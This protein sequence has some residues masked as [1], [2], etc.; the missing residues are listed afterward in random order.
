[1][2]KLFEIMWTP[3]LCSFISNKILVVAETADQAIE[4]LRNKI[5]GAIITMVIMN[6]NDLI[7]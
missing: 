1:M 5:P 3:D 6:I 4:K 7:E 2:K